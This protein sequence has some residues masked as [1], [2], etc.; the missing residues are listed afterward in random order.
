MASTK[1]T[2]LEEHF[3]RPRFYSVLINPYF[4]NRFSLYT[5][6]QRFASATTATATILDV[7]CGIKPYRH[8][9]P[10]PSYTGIDI[11]GGG[12]EDAAKTVEAFY[13]GHT[14][15]FPD[16]SFDTILCTQVLEHADDPEILVRECAR[17]L[18]TGGCAFFSM[19]FV[20]PEHEVPYDFR[21]FTR[22]EH[23]RLFQKNGFQDITITQTTG[24]FG[25]FGQLFVVWMFENLTFRAPLLK[26]ALSLFIFA[27]VQTL[28]LAL[29]WLF[30]KSGPTMDYVITLKK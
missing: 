5:A 3:F 6:I 22:F 24:I 17:V 9:F 7:G 18:K 16:N 15:P 1:Q 29:D 13:D 27:P 10:T 11:A 12:H 14:I 21:R 2:F 30:D 25:T 23:T 20:Y 28:A 26:A 4:I 19:P 8:L